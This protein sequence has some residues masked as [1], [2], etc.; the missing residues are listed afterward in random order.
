MRARSLQ[1]ARQSL[2]DAGASVVTQRLARHWSQLAWLKIVSALPL[3]LNVPAVDLAL[4]FGSSCHADVQFRFIN[5]N[6]VEA[7]NRFSHFQSI[8]TSAFVFL[9]LASVCKA[10]AADGSVHSKGEN[11]MRRRVMLVLAS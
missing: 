9:G 2:T 11:V 1:S 5:V 8:A 10:P 6:L 7:T 4:T 3:R